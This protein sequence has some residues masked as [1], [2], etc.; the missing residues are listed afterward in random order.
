[1]LIIKNCTQIIVK[2]KN[3]DGTFTGTSYF[4]IPKINQIQFMNVK[5]VKVLIVIENTF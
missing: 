1:M 5:K 2:N 4:T 3:N